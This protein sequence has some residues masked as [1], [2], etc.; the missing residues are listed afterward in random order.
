M[1]SPQ[2]EQLPFEH[3][4]LWQSLPA[5][6]ASPAAQR[7]HARFVPPQ[8]VSDSL[9][10]CRP[11]LQVTATHEPLPQLPLAQSSSM[12]QLAPVP[13]RAQAGLP[14]P[15][16]VSVSLPFWAASSH[17]TQ[18]PAS[19]APLAQSV[20]SRQASPSG[21][22]AHSVLEPPQSRPDSSP[23]DKPSLQLATPHTP[24]LHTRLSQS[25]G[26]RHGEPGGQPGQLPPPQSASSSPALWAPSWHAPS[27]H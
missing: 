27:V 14:P 10:F 24:S 7:E 25:L 18:L 5:L 16:S 4:W 17:D 21:Q 19:H 13:Q 8:S 15:Q 3:S 26:S 6:Q 20:A 9:P 1:P 22:R 11:S 23:L 2:G 12:L